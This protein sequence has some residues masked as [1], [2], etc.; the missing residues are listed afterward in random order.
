MNF[1]PRHY[2]CY[3]SNTI[4]V[5]V[6]PPFIVQALPLQ[7]P[8]VCNCSYWTG[9]FL[10]VLRPVSHSPLENA[11]FLLGTKTDLLRSA[12]Q[13]AQQHGSRDHKSF[14]ALLYRSGAV[15]YNV[16]NKIDQGG[17]FYLILLKWG[18]CQ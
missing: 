3:D 17:L 13:Q 9:F 7:P 1:I 15:I 4:S 16:C 11:P 12:I 8:P 5:R 10:V 6:R 14:V 2:K 18:A